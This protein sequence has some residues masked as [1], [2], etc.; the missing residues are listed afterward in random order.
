[1]DPHIHIAVYLS[2]FYEKKHFFIGLPFC[3]FWLFNGFNG[4]MVQWWFKL[5]ERSRGSSGRAAAAARPVRA[6]VAPMPKAVVPVTTTIMKTLASLKRS[7]SSARL[8]DTL[9][10]TAKDQCRT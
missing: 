10:A 6:S 4:S 7:K 5:R 1:L 9:E 8:E 3:F 2:G